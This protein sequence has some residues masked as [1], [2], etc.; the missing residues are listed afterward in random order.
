[1]PSPKRVHENART[2]TRKEV[3]IMSRF[4]MVIVVAAVLAL[5]GCASGPPSSIGLYTDNARAQS[6]KGSWFQEER[7]YPYTADE[8]REASQTA[9]LRKGL[10][11]E[12]NDAKKGRITASGNY[13]A[14]CGGGPCVVALTVAVYVE[15][16]SPK[17]LTKMTLFLDRHGM[18]GWGGGPLLSSEII[19]ETQKI[20]STYK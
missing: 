18:M 19:T 9:L 14:L 4:T 16:I 6:I 13:H 7:T 1:M 5:I 11:V 12:E 3:I 15:Q 10:S 20:L 17:P 8:V 2:P